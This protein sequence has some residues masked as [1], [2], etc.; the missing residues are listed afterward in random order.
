MFSW[1]TSKEITRRIIGFVP[2]YNLLRFRA[3]NKMWKMYIDQRIVGPFVK[4][5]DH[6]ELTAAKNSV[7]YHEARAL[8]LKMKV[9]TV[10]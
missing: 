6:E 7:S 4:L 10:D 3:V 2:A 1:E 5:P 9:L 8:A